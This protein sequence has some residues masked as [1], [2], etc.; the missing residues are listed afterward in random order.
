MPHLT[1]VKPLRKL[2]F[3]IIL[4]SRNSSAQPLMQTVADAHKLKD[5]EQRFINKPLK[6]LLKEIGPEIRVVLAEGKRAHGALSY[7]VFWFVDKEEYKKYSCAGKDPPGIRVMIKE[8]F[9]WD[10]QKRKQ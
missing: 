6:T 2:L 3:L 5:D 7:F 8:R 9:D 4:F 10:N 1:V